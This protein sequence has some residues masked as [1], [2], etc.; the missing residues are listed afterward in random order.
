MVRAG[1][2]FNFFKGFLVFTFDFPLSCLKD[3]ENRDY[4]LLLEETFPLLVV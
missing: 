3:Y 2:S 4:V 1:V